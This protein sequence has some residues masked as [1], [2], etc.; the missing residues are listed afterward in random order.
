MAT[1]ARDI[2]TKQID[3]AV[4]PSPRSAIVD[5]QADPRGGYWALVN[6]PAYDNDAEHAFLL[7][8]DDTHKLIATHAFDVSDWQDAGSTTNVAAMSVGM[9]G[10]FVVGSIVWIG[11][12]PTLPSKVF[13]ARFSIDGI[14]QA[15]S[16]YD[17]VLLDGCQVPGR[18]HNSGVGI[19]RLP[20]PDDD[21]LMV[22]FQTA[23]M[24]DG[25]G[26]PRPDDS[27]GAAVFTINDNGDLRSVG[28]KRIFGQGQ[29]MPARLRL[30]PTLGPTIVGRTRLVSP[31]T[32]S[33][34]GYVARVD[35]DGNVVRD[36][37]Y[38]VDDAKSV[39]LNDIAED[40]TAILTVG[41]VE[42]PD[43]TLRALSMR[44]ETDGSVDWLGRYDP[45]PPGPEGFNT[46]LVALAPKDGVW[47]AGGAMAQSGIT[48][49]WLVSLTSASPDPVWQ[50][51]Y[52]DR[53][54]KSDLPA[55][56]DALLHNL[57]NRVIAGGEIVLRYTAGAATLYER[58]SFLVASETAPGDGPPR[59][60]K[61]TA[62]RIVKP[63][64]TDLPPTF[65][66]DRMPLI[67][68]EAL[69]TK[70]DPQ[71]ADETLCP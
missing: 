52:P 67:V 51:W 30:L 55:A 21:R 24:F 16:V 46:Q 20:P 7:K 43:T 26:L 18:V 5:L 14:F 34:F 68:S 61:E 63:N 10:I 8:F 27:I 59:C 25:F 53:F 6:V 57:P 32:S 41:T 60:S 11:R 19:V 3:L 47:I 15:V 56:F 17:P 38:A 66:T 12:R 36:T 49:P 35:R 50:K 71:I 69:K 1:P 13:V 58:L 23:A 44:I 45:P 29:V 42:R 62:T 2:V 39:V 37:S 54:A 64:V 65:W 4:L 48:Y 9:R 40:S 28:V 70:D 31:S 22:L 33:W